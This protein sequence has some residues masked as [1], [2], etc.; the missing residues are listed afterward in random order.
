MPPRAGKPSPQKLGALRCTYD[1]EAF[2]IGAGFSAKDRRELWDMRGELPGRLVKFR[3]Q[4]LTAAGKP[5]HASY[6]GL[7]DSADMA[8]TNLDQQGAD[9]II[10][11]DDGA[12]LIDHYSLV[13]ASCGG[14]SVIATTTAGDI[15]LKGPLPD[16]RTARQWAEARRVQKPGYVERIYAAFFNFD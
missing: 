2:S 6:L 1:G 4:G 10:E 12:V 15:A 8:A 5:R 9:M 3:F 16:K 11:I 13:R 14:W 7:R